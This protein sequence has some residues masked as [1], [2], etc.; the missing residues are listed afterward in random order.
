MELERVVLAD[1]YFI[2][3]KLYPNVD[4]YSGLIF[5]ALGLS[6]AMFTPIFAVAR[7]VGWVA[8]WNEMRSRNTPLSPAPALR[9]AGRTAAGP[10]RRAQDAPAAR[11]LKSALTVAALVEFGPGLI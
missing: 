5:R 10:D 2:A 1:D 3:R 7:T 6:P 4:F 11:R 8:H 9:W